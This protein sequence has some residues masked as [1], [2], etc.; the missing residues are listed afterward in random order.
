M[1]P[2]YDP[3]TKKC[4]LWDTYQTDYAIS[5]YCLSYNWEMNCPNYRKKMFG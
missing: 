4:R 2:Y 3:N 1:C 5:A